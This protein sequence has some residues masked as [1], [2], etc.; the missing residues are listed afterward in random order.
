MDI[1]LLWPC[2]V[3]YALPLGQWHTW[4][5]TTYMLEV[6][7]MGMYY[8]TNAQHTFQTRYYHFMDMFNYVW[9]WLFCQ[10]LHCA[11]RRSIQQNLEFVFSFSSPSHRAVYRWQDWLHISTSL[12]PPSLPSCS[13]F[14]VYLLALPVTCLLHK[15][16][17]VWLCS[18]GMESPHFSL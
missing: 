17:L 5:H 7:D 6:P 12:S 10:C 15:C 8:M 13:I 11:S 1:D 16:H 18:I 9:D 4:W 2:M 14:V 3:M